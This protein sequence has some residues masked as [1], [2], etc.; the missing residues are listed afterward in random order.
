M[1]RV[2][3]LTGT[4]ADFGKLKS[5]IR[6]TQASSAFDVHVFATGMHMNAKFGK[7]INEIHKS[8]FDNIYGFINHDD[9]G[10]MDRA[11]AKTVDGFSHYLAEICPDLVVVHG[12]R[13]EALAGAIVGSLNN[14]LVAHVEGGEIS[15]TIDELIRHSISK[16]A[17]IHLVSNDEAARRLIQM[18]ERPGSIHVIGSPDLD[19][20]FSSDLPSLD[21][22]KAYY[23]IPFDDFALGILHPVTTELDA[24]VECAKAYVDALTESGHRF[25][26]I[27][28][29]ND[30]GSDAILREYE[31]LRLHE[32]FRLFP[33]VR[34]E[35]FIVLLR[36]ARLIVGNSSAGIREAPEFGI[37][38][39]DIGTRQLNR[40]R[41]PTIINCPPR[42]EAILAAMETAKLLGRDTRAASARRHFGSGKSDQAF[43][44]LLSTEAFWQTPVQKQFQSVA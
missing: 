11:L 6:I 29:N 12:D 22:V 31:R 23:E 43:L 32:R 7:T 30:P 27:H 34:F 38:T 14:I 15:G 36:A 17:H 5:L 2:V 25:V 37:P 10:R 16:L 42:R 4:R 41:L 13:A 9:V 20:M 26:L 18:G 19:V 35:A 33:S 1:K 3:F 40:A 44:A 39:V 28:P 8:G 21:S 24:T